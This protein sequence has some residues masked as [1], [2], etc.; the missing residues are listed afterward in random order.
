VSGAAGKRRWAWW[1]FGLAVLLVLDGLGWATYQALRYERREREARAEG[2]WQETIRLA[3]WRLETELAPVLAQEAAR[4][5]FQYRFSYPVGRAYEAM[6]AP[7]VG[8]DGGV[9]EVRVLSPIIEPSGLYTK[10]HYQVE[11]G[12]VLTSPQAASEAELAGVNAGAVSPEVRM[13]GVHRLEA[14]RGLWRPPLEP[15]AVGRG[16]V[17]DGVQASWRDDREAGAGQAAMESAKSMAL[18]SVAVAEPEAVAPATDYQARQ[19]A[20]QSAQSYADQTQNRG[21]AD[22]LEMA[23]SPMSVPAPLATE[24]NMAAKPAAPIKPAKLEAED[25]PAG[26]EQGPFEARWLI[27]GRTMT[28]DDRVPDELVI[29]RPV[30][31]GGESVMQGVWLDWPSLERRL[32]G[33]IA[34]L[35]PQA[36]LRPRHEDHEWVPQDRWLAAIPAVIVPGE[37]PVLAPVRWSSLRTTLI[38]TWLAVLGAIGAIGWVLRSSMELSDRRGRF[39]SAVTHELRTPLTTFQLYTDMLASGMVTEPASREAYLKTLQQESSRL[40]RLVENVLVYSRLSEGRSIAGGGIKP[41]GE[42]WAMLERVRPMLEARAQAAGMQLEVIGTPEPVRVRC[43]EASLE[44]LLFN[45]VDNAAKYAEGSADPRIEVRVAAAKD[46]GA[47]AG[48]GRRVWIDVRDFGAGVPEEERARIFEPFYQSMRSDEHP[49]AGLGLGLALA[50][51]L[52]RDL[53]GEVEMMP[54]DGVGARF[55]VWLVLVS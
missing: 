42:L 22:S 43:D 16:A 6:W 34:D 24:P 20:A 21:R 18:P 47:G 31:V 8:G 15:K 2:K 55:R 50:R 11:P 26:I 4:P 36:T 37:A 30:R 33:S 29:E 7:A 49:K 5:Y 9:P 12:G 39:V 44:R 19:R 54:S 17:L 45:L 23:D 25:S 28:D 13:L 38:V 53:G 40:S 27:S 35:L 32:R 51:G 46:A 41:E 14:L 10:L 52:A 48:V 1:I 3:L